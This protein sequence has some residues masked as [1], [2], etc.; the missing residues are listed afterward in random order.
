MIRRD[1]PPWL[2]IALA[3]G[4]IIVLLVAYEWMSLR[5]T[6]INPKQTTI[7]SFAKL[8]EGVQRVFQMQ[9]TAENPKPPMFWSDVGA[10]LWRLA[11]G[12]TI[13]VVA[14]VLVGVLMGCYRWIEAPL[15]PV[16]MFMS[17]VPP[18]A[19]MPLYFAIAGIGFRMYVLMVALGVFFSM[20]QAIFQAVRD[21]VT[22]EAISKAYTLGASEFEVIVEVIWK[23]ILP[24]VL[25]CIRSQIGPAMIYLL[26]AE[27]S[28]G[29]PGVGCQIRMQ[30]KLLN[31][32]IIFF[33]IFV[34]GVLGLAL[35]FGLVWFRKWLCPWFQEGR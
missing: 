11:V 18:I 8:A 24:N 19:I 31:F 21:N 34:L 28:M 27:Y 25:D 23:Q 10:T 5:Q 9:G 13:G 6:A 17:K 20:T 12:L 1:L 26:A 29:E 4:G 7:P 30:Y 14:S 32:H 15:S 35:E 33:Y 3:I 22:D 2:F 16:I